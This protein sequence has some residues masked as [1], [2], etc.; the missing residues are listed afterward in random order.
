MDERWQEIE[1]VYHA[2]R[3]LTGSARTEFLAKAFGEN[4]DLRH[5]VESLLAQADQVGSFLESPA[6]EVAAEALAKEGSARRNE[7]SRP[8]GTT[9]SHYQILKKLGGGGMG[10]VYEAEDTKLGRRVALKFLPAEMASDARALERFQREARAASALNHPNICTIHDVGE[11]EGRPFIVMEMMEGAT[12]KHRIEGRP[13]K[14]DLLLDWAIEIADALNAAHSKGIIHRDIKP[15]NIFV[16]TRGQAKILDFGLAKLTRVGAGPVPA[17]GRPQGA[18]L[19][20]SAA[21]VPAATIDREQLTSRGV[22]MGTL[23]YMSPEQARGEPLDARTDLFSFGAVL[24]EMATGRPAF[25]GESTA[26]IIAKILKEEPPSPRSLNP[27][28]PAKLEEIIAKC[29]EKDR[30]LRCQTAAEIRADL[31]RLKRDTS[32][33]HSASAAAVSSQAGTAAGTSPFQTTGTSTLKEDT[34]SQVFAAL[35]KRHKKGFFGGL[36]VVVVALAILVYWLM[37][38]LPPPTVSGYTQL[39]Q[40]AVSKALIG[41]DGSRLYLRESGIGPAQMSV[42][43]GNVAPI[44]QAAPAQ[45]VLWLVKSVSPDGSE[46]LFQQGKGWSNAAGPLW[47]WPTLGG[48]PVRLAD[49]DGSGGAWSP[50]GQKLAYVNGTSLYLAN[51]DGTASRKLADLP[52]ILPFVSH[53]GMA[54]ESSLKWSPSGKEIALT[55]ENPKTRVPHLW[56]LSADGRELHRMFPGWHEGAGECCGSWMPDGKY[57]VFQSQSQIWAVREVGSFLHT[58]RH[59]PV[60]LTA[61]AVR[62]GNAVPGKDGKKLFAVAY[63]RRG[64][65]ERYD[66]RTKAFEPFLGGISA[67]FVSFSKDGK[68][69]AYVTYPQGILWRSKLDGS[70]K[71]QLSSPPLYAALPRW[72]PDGREIA[73]YAFQF[74]QADRRY[75]SYLVPSAGGSPQELTPNQPGPQV[76]VVWSPDGK[77]LLFG[78]PLGVPTALYTVNVKTRQVSPIPGSKGL[79]SPRWSPDGRY[80]V[81]LTADQSSVMLFDFHTRKWTTL[82]KAIAGFANWAR[83]SRSVFVSNESSQSVSR[84]A[85]PGGKVEQV[86]SLKGIQTTGIFNHWLGLTPDDEPLVLK[87]TGTQEIVSMD[88]HGP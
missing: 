6:L 47:A 51:A 71:L 78:G 68:W 43:G 49:I 65:L 22:A 76:D 10:V 36:A 67:E 81:A 48:S 39:T 79:F 59:K 25:S 15:A 82:L 52:G 60:Q 54:A 66:A 34:D 46:L 18:P 35:L 27:E 17:Q 5:E 75:R 37:P 11:E 31:K 88:F 21:D 42:N 61:G 70:D 74:N 53:P 57:F 23:G 14:I 32:S 3:E 41:T 24:Y 62:Y 86:V 13:I 87:N 26:E 20:E 19:Q 55:L 16:T 80:L 30:D 45:G 1:R 58:V 28:L 2:A 72:S 85:V 56:E 33:S 77:S 4:K 9:V 69:V 63:F 40:D 64:E 83:D 50:D 8:A 73:Y 38:P 44:P 7:D 12:L 29:L 84:I